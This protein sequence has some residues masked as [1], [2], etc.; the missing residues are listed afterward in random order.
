MQIKVQPAEFNSLLLAWHKKHGRHDLPWR[1][2]VSPYRVWV[3]E[4]MLQQTR[5]RTV[6]PYFAAFIKR[7]P[8]IAA[9][10][11]ASL[12]EVLHL[13]TGLGYY[14]RARHLHQAAGLIMKNHAGI[15]PRDISA[16]MALPGVG[17]STA[18]AILAIA[19]N[20]SLPVLDGNVKRVLARYHIIEGWTGSA[21]IQKRLWELAENF[22]P[23]NRVAE[24]TQAIM[25]LGATVC[26]RHN[27]DCAQCP[28]QSGC[29]AN[30]TLRQY[31][32]P[33]PRP[34]KQLPVRRK[35]F[36]ILENR[37]GEILL[38][39]RPPTGIWGGLWSFPECA[40]EQDIKLWLKK[41]WG[42]TTNRMEY[43]S[44]LM[45]TFSHFRLD[46]IPVHV[47]VD[48]SNAKIHD[49]GQYCW[50]KPAENRL[51]GMATPVR[52]LMQQITGR[53]GP[54]ENING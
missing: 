29:L 4:I 25:D 1:Q 31:E 6:I 8:D 21:A 50:C 26:I 15:F 28:V 41:Q 34:R 10:A 33:Y 2:D 54:Q 36:A 51:I 40:P 14:A 42:Y 18:G 48:D 38:E 19:T 32:L 49:T 9:L 44:P 24:Y 20:Q 37:A 45:H 43:K 16:L 17:R 47:M 53:S 13:W 5:V 30:K 3:S 39:Q 52:K 11:G 12:D 7:F 23:A 46:I 27:P 22:T 35:V